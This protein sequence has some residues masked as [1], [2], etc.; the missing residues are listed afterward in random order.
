[1]AEAARNTYATTSG[2]AAAGSPNQVAVVNDGTADRQVVVLGAG[3]GTSTLVDGTSANPLTHKLTNGTNIADV[4]AGDAGFNGVATASATKTITFTTSTSGAQV[5][6]ANTNLEGYASV[7]VVYNSVGAGLALSGQF[8][9]A[10]AGT[11]VTSATFA[12]GT[13]GFNGA[14]GTTVNTIYVSPIRGNYFQINVTAL[15]SGTF[16]GT[17]TLRA[18]L[19]NAGGFSATQSG[20]WTVGSNSA[21]GSAVPANAFYGGYQNNAGSLIGFISSLKAGNTAA[22]SDNVLPYAPYVYNGTSN[23]KTVSASSAS[24]TTGTGLLGIGALAV[25]ATALPSAATATNYV[26]TM[27]DK[28]GRQVVLPQAPR[29]L[30]GQQ[31]TTITSSTG[32]TTVVTAGAAGVLNDITSITLTNSSASATLATLSDGT[33]SYYF[34]CPAGDMRGA[35]YQV[36]L[37]ATA[38]ATAWTLTCGTSVASLYV[39]VQFVK[40]Q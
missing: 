5:I 3:D 31:S 4:V 23:D 1:M 16:S 36:P 17:V 6:L 35:T 20:T 10:S 38:A 21:T 18:S 22:S 32:S 14:L 12:A 15:T 11:Y 37:A 34:Y 27:A 8:S 2:N 19:P 30:V 13:S 24:N 28:F 29:D 25:A 26:R 9:T 39:T 7:E 40:N 33:N